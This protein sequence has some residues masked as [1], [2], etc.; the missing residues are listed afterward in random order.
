MEIHFK[1]ENLKIWIYSEQLIPVSQAILQCNRYATIIPILHDVIQ[2]IEPFEY[3][4]QSLR[5]P[6]Q[7]MLIH[8]GH[9]GVFYIETIGVYAFHR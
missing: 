7:N 9:F 8:L 2:Q 1:I 4:E 5:E 3:L 6:L